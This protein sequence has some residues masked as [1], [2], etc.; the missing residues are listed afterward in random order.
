M[1]GAARMHGTESPG[2][3]RRHA[4]PLFILV[5]AAAHG[6][7]L[8]T[9]NPATPRAGAESSAAPTSLAVVIAAPRTVPPAE[10][11]APPPQVQAAAPR[12]P[13]RVRTERSERRHAQPA[14]VA[15][16]E[17]A[18]RVAMTEIIE[19]EP[20][21]AA[22]VAAAVEQNA[23]RQA[24]NLS[25]RV[26]LELA[27]HFNYP[28]IAVRRNWQG[29]VL[30]GFRIGVNGDIEAVH[31]ARS[32]GYALLDRAALGALGKVQRVAL[33]HGP[34]RAALDLQLPVIYRLEES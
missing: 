24:E 3:W 26:D 23:S 11:A 21:R 32:S 10:Q 22:A 4:L 18:P 5:S 9:W 27:R 2:G 29:T 16:T 28:S 1:S 25:A 12:P 7:L 17:P 14:T 8:A 34:L 31:I 13:H 15:R 6:A 19:P 20:D 30:L 33:D